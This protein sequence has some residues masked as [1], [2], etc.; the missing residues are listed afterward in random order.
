MEE[1]T[2]RIEKCDGKVQWDEFILE[3]G[4]HPLQLWGWGDVRDTLGW[5][6]DRL[7]VVEEDKQIGAAQIFIKRLPRPFGLC[8]YIPRGPLIVSNE[9][10]VYEQLITYVKSTYH[11]IAL[12]VEPVTEGEPAGTGWQESDTHSL[13]PRT[14]LLDLSK[15]DGVLLADMD[16]KTRDRIRVAGQEGLHV[17]KLANPVDVSA[18]YQLYKESCGRRGEKPYKE[19]YFH[20]LQDKLG[21]FSVIFGIYEQDTLLSFLWLAV[22]ETVAVEIYSGISSR[23]GFETAADFGLRWEAI[24][25]IKQWGVSLYDVG[26]TDPSNEA[27]MKRGFGNQY[28]D[29]GTFVLP[30]SPMYNIWKKASRDR[31]HFAR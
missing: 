6:I 2:Y 15:A 1:K 7:F 25:R 22:S 11:G 30:M 13:A 20:D 28:I 24:R 8:L 16:Q 23:R 3:N 18:C 21:E 10:A 29:R 5:Q 27:D 14:I 31:S 26:G 19:K 4:G 9:T 17:K 12:I